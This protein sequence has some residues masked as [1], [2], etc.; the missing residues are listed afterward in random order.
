M[1][2]SLD[3]LNATN[4]THDSLNG[5]SLQVD[6]DI[7][8][9]KVPTDDPPATPKARLEKLHSRLGGASFRPAASGSRHSSGSRQKRAQRVQNSWPHPEK[10][11]YRSL[12]LF[13]L[14]NPF[15]KALI[16]AI[17][18]RW[19]DRIVLIVIFL[20]TII[21]ALYDPYDIVQLRPVSVKRNAFDWISKA[22]SIFFAIECVIKILALGFCVGRRTYLSD[23][24]N[25]LDLTVVSNKP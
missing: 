7:T 5:E 6:Q 13:T 21:L 8:V 25:Y 2:L 10:Y 12:Y 17:E 20:N 3:D 4:G 11:N 1:S 14:N 18:W 15:R 23:S 9:P 24:W 22:F 19:W 16:A